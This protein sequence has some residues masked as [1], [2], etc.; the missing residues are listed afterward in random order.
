MQK[1]FDFVELLR[2]NY[3]NIYDIES[4]LY[5]NRLFYIKFLVVQN[6]AFSRTCKRLCIAQ[7]KGYFKMC[8]P[9][10]LFNTNN[11]FVVTSIHC[12]RRK[13]IAI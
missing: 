7:E 8:S 2:I 5:K 3:Q 12:G 4:Y 13:A 11:M 9:I 6:S 1:H 10:S